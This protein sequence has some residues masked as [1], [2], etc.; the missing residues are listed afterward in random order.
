MQISLNWLKQYVDIPKD[1]EPKDLALKLTMATV[2]IENI[3]DQ[4]ER[5]NNIIVGEII[6]IV[7]H[8]DATKLKVCRVKTGKEEYQIVCGGAN[9]YQGLKGV[10]ALPG[11]QVKWHGQGEYVK[12]EK[13]K[14]RGIESNGMLCAAEEVDLPEIYSVNGGVVDLGAKVKIGQSIAEVFGLDDVIFEIDNKSITHRSDLWGHYGLAREIAAIFDTKLGQLK[15]DILKEG[16]EVDLKVEIEDNEN[17]LRY[18]AVAIGNVK[19]EASPD[20]LQ[21]FLKAVGIRPIN[22]IVDISNFVM[23]ELGQPTHAFDRKDITDDTIIIKR[24][25]GKEKYRTLDNIERELD[26]NTLL[27]CDKKRPVALAGVMGGLNSEVEEK[28]E[29]IIFEVANFNPVNIR[30]TATRL[31]LRTDAATRFEKGLDPGLVEIGMKRVITLI[32]ELLPQARLT[33]KVIDINNLKAEARVIELSLDF[34]KRR[35]GIEIP[36][37]EVIRILESLSFKVSDKKGELSV[38][39]PDFRTKKDIF[40]VEDLVEEI[41]RIYGYDNIEQVMPYISMEPQEYNQER[42]IERQ[43]KNILVNVGGLNEVLNYSFISEKQIL[44]LGL[45]L[46]NHLELKNTLSQDQKYLRS[47]LIFNLLHNVSDN[48]RFFKECKLFELGR[49][50]NLKAGEYSFSPKSKELLSSQSKELAGVVINDNPFIEVKGL[51][52][53]LLNL[54]EVKY[55]LRINKNNSGHVLDNTKCL[56]II[57]GDNLIGYLGEVDKKILSK[58]EIKVKVGYF[59]INYKEF[60]K[61]VADNLKYEPLPKYPGMTYDLSI[62]VP[63]KVNWADLEQE[64]RSTSKLIQQVELFDVYQ[65]SK[66]GPNKRSLAFHIH[67]LDKKRTLE[68]KEVEKIREEIVKK[69]IKKFKAE[70]R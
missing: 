58:N 30:K 67:F 37:K 28:T 48:L 21:N 54:L 34:L 59:Q 14:I 69:L 65:V 55:E 70:I 13:T 53:T 5:F 44:N 43:V 2:E 38:T 66:L 61:H 60:L 40:I 9:I 35:V 12:L 52:E 24:A 62:I 33:S 57:I 3:I 41:A 20:W 4:R 25:K 31:D 32:H 18:M 11:A 6:D 10:L 50:F 7:D 46:E 64:V 26:L 51:V 8:P 29:E 36:K 16:K 63:F 56:E 27:I 17:C 23:L 45:E 42:E 22:N 68:T 15:T 47:S 1:L 39:V 19:I 49:V